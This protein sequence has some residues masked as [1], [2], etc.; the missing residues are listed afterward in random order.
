MRL[1]GRQR[2]KPEHDPVEISEKKGIRYLHLGGPAV[3]SAM[4]IKDPYALELEY[5]RAMMAFLLF[6]PAP[7]EIALVGLGGASIAKFIHRSLP[8]ARLT[9]LEINPDVVSAARSYFL[10]PDDDARL[11]VRVGDGAAYVRGRSDG[12]DVLLVD[13]YDAHRIVDALAS[14]DFYAACLAALAPSG[15]AVFNLWGSDRFFDVYAD[16]IGRVFADHTLILPAEKKG[17]IQMF[18]F[19]PPLPDTGFAALNRRARELEARLGLE[20]PVFV[21]RMKLYNTV[22]GAA[23]RL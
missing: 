15:V 5:T 12:L 11:T 17:N 20:M 8:E 19:R 22:L 10:L 13:G 4:R 7:R 18:A 16:R 3:Q 14:E 21:E 23:F 9:A 1:F 6:H 2:Q